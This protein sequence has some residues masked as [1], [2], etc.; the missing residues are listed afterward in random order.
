MALILLAD[1]DAASLEFMKRS[2]S[3][4][5]HDVTTVQDGLDA[6]DRL[7]ANEG[8]RFEIL[9]TDI[10][11]PGLDGIELAKKA[12]SHNPNLKILL[13]S[14]FATGV[15]RAGSVT[16]PNVMALNKP[17]SLEQIRSAVKSLAR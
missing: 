15:D 17:L 14:G 5:G 2:L 4:D 12:L 9:I 11:M 3:G 6:L 7:T 13:V 16:G 10:E 8:R 1:D